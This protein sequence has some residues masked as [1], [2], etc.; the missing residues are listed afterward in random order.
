MP[1][2]DASPVEAQIES[3]KDL[4]DSLP[5]EQ[6]KVD[7][8]STLEKTLRLLEDY[9]QAI[10]HLPTQERVQ[11]EGVLPGLERLKTFLQPVKAPRSRGRSASG[12]QAVDMNRIEQFVGQLQRL[13]EAELRA[14]IRESKLSKAEWL[15]AVQFVG[16][17]ATSR[18]SIDLLKQK[19]AQEIINQRTHEGLL[20][21]ATP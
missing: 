2:K 16:G 10:A 1:R 6:D 20:G 8:L 14:V 5:R 7:Y 3:L 19:L 13:P 18:D 4:F 21:G 11:A 12:Q 15:A 17:R 9:R